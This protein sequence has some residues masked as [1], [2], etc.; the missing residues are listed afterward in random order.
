MQTQVILSSS[1]VHQTHCRTLWAKSK[2][3][4]GGEKPAYLSP[5]LARWGLELAQ[6]EQE[7]GTVEQPQ[8]VG[9]RRLAGS[10]TP[11]KQ[12]RKQLLEGRQRES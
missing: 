5:C 7:E 2:V 12:S 1:R 4:V 8:A 6:E 11:E 9:C 3:C 10:G